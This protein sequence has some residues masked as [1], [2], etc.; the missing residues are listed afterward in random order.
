MT[1]LPALMGDVWG[2]LIAFVFLYPL[3]MSFVW[4]IGAIA[5]YFLYER[6]PHRVVNQPLH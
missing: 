4:S 1:T 5:F 6:H 3:F 2:M